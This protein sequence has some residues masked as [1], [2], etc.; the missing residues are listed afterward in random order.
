MSDE[1]DERGVEAAAWRTWERCRSLA[2]RKAGTLFGQLSDE[3]QDAWREGAR[4]ALIAYVAAAAPTKDEPQC[5]CGRPR[6][7]DGGCNVFGFDWPRPATKD[8]LGQP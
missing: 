6:H 8:E 3:T 2:E 5:V 7:H 1:L 4:V